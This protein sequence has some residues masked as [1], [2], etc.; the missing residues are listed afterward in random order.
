M[1]A[2]IGLLAVGA[3]SCG[4][5]PQQPD[6]PVAIRLTS[7][8]VA[9]VAAPGLIDPR[10]TVENETE[11]LTTDRAAWYLS[12][13]TGGHT[14][15]KIRIEWR[16]PLG[17][18][19][20]QN[21]HTQA[22]EGGPMRLA[23]KM[24]IAGAPAAFVPGDWQVRLFW[25]D[26]GVSVTNFKISTPPD[27][28][29]TMVSR[30]VLPS[31]TTGVPYYFQLTARG[32]V[33]PYRWTVLKSF[34]AGL[35]LSP[36]GTVTGTPEQRGSF[37][38]TVEA[39]DSNDG[40]V[41]RTFGIGIGA[42]AAEAR[43]AAHI[44]LKSAVPDACSQTTSQ[45]EFSVSDLSVVLATLV[46][47]RKGSEGRIE[48]LNPRGE[49][50]V[51]K[52]V[53]KTAEGPECIVQ[54]L[55]LAGQRA[56][57]APGDWRVRLFWRDAE[58]FTLNFSIAGAGGPANPAPARGGRLAVVLG[59][60]APSDLD[61]VATALHDDGFEVVRNA[62]ANLEE[63]RQ[64]ERTLSDKLHEGDTVLV[65]YAGSSVRSGGD[66]WLVPANYDRADPRPI[67][68]KAYS[69]LRLLQWLEDSK[70]SLKFVILDAAGVSGEP[71]EN[72]GAVMGEVDDSTA[73]VFSSPPGAAAKAASPAPDVFGRAF[74]EV[75]RKP[76]LDARDVLQIEL[77]KAISRLAPSGP[78]PTAIL[79]GGA[80]FVF[81]IASKR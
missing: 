54:A 64:V 22:A 52:R 77:P 78:Q 32:G 44:L 20:Q 74:A 34:P 7:V 24:L 2:W 51:T 63:L 21:D 81:R 71:R 69:V 26:Q 58:M 23:Y 28:T 29:V 42:P 37:R 27:S 17:A 49:V 53:P 47:A 14:G 1:R 48:W 13:Y 9:R 31:G 38:A 19:A 30:T 25:N 68:S 40:S 57:S 73:L 75:L 66:E 46:R 56:A 35:S 36:A 72:A 16:N 41:A 11:F 15:D 79:G 76:G 39:K 8:H 45:T 12:T 18:L 50:A 67:Q 3:L 4:A 33:P 62:G 43:N 10:V 61:L 55:P 6:Q 70:A 80:D 59:S 5:A 60:S 65:Y